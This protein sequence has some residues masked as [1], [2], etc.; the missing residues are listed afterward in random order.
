MTYLPASD[1][2]IPDRQPS[3]NVHA[4]VLIPC[5]TCG[6]L[7]RFESHPLP[8]ATVLCGPCWDAEV[9]RLSALADDGGAYYADALDGAP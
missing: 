4:H 9:A 1:C 3:A 2:W 5:A 8:E 7:E 6:A